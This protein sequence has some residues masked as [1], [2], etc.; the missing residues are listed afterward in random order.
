V[1]RHAALTW[2]W[3]IVDIICFSSRPKIVSYLATVTVLAENYKAERVAYF[4]H[5]ILLCAY[6]IKVTQ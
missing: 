6:D 5:V 1:Y 4:I 2:C 3:K